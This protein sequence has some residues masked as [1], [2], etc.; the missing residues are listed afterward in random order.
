LIK[1]ISQ[2]GC[3]GDL[4]DAIQNIQPFKIIADLFHVSSYFLGW[5]VGVKSKPNPIVTV[6]PVVPPLSL[7]FSEVW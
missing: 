1:T 3:F 7:T 2:I 4:S 5:V 6:K